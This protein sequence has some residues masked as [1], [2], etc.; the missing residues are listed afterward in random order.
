MRRL[1]IAIITSMVFMGSCVAFLPVANRRTDP[2]TRY[3]IGQDSR[4]CCP[5]PVLVVVGGE[6]RLLELTDPSK[7]PPLPA[8]ATYLV[9]D[10]KDAAFQRELNRDPH[11]WR[12]A[13]WVLNVR[14]LSPGHQ[15]IE[16]YLMG[17]GFAGGVYEATATSVTLLYRK[18]TGPGYT[19]IVGLLALLMNAAVWGL[20]RVIVLVRRRRRASR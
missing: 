11:A 1:A 9:P 17:D 6:P 4:L 15:R 12:D 3:P 16:L 8:G 5:F 10:G 20:V 2:I 7:V 19:F 13:R 18:I 14:R